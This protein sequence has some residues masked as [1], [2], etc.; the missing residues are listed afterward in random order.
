MPKPL[1]QSAIVNQAL[2]RLGST[3]R[4]ASIDD[5]K[6]VARHAAA[7]WD[8]ALRHI[9]GDHPWNF[10]IARVQLPETLPAPAFGW[11]RAFDLPADCLRFLPPR[12]GD[13]TFY[14]CEVEDGRILTD[15]AAPLPVRYIASGKLDDTA[16]WPPYF[17]MAMELELAS[18]MAEAVT[19]ASGLDDKLAEK[20]EKAVKI[21]KRRDGLEGG[22]AKR[23]GATARGSWTR[24]T[25]GYQRE[26]DNPRDRGV[27]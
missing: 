11:E 1:T 23:A 4:I 15:S 7:H 16:K 14:C 5:A 12:D 26:G 22:R 10:A 25:R 20:A 18:R 19:G 27:V 2:S 21:A 6:E 9:A 8:A 3:E 17:A 13:D 24:A